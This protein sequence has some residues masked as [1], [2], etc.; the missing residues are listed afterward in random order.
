MDGSAIP[1]EPGERDRRVVIQQMTDS[2][3]T[4]GFPVEAPTTLA[5]VWM[6]MLDVSGLER[7]TAQQLSGYSVTQ[8]EMGYRSDM[9]PELVN[10]VKTR[11]LLYQGRTY[12]ITAAS[13]IGRR[14]GIELITLAKV[15]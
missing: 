10:V 11:Q 4:S 1:M 3:A 14:E 9:D 12:D 7:Y 13:M 6:R 5:T 8:W 15:G 2:S